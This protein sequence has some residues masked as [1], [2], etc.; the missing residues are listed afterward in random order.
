[1]ITNNWK[2]LA[3][4]SLIYLI[5]LPPKSKNLNDPDLVHLSFLFHKQVSTL[6]KINKVTLTSLKLQIKNNLKI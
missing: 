1:M 6:F 2:I 4:L 5:T 3:S